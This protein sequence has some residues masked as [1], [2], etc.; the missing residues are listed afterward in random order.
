MQTGPVPPPG[1]QPPPADGADD[2]DT[3]HIGQP[4]GTPDRQTHSAANT[5]TAPTMPEFEERIASRIEAQVQA[6]I[7]DSM[8]KLSLTLLG[9]V[10]SQ[11]SSSG[12]TTSSP[13]VVPDTP[14]VGLAAAA[15]R[16]AKE[17]ADAAAA[18]Q[19]RDDRRAHD[20]S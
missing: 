10:G 9:A 5:P 12:Q 16:A 17:A 1:T 3:G 7:A 18:A 8:S 11:S 15:A 4:A 20:S 14:Q 6:Q 19:T 13:Q 2:H